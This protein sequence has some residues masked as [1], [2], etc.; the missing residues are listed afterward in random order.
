MNQQDVAKL[1]SVVAARY[2]TSKV[3]E[4]DEALT[5]QAWHMTLDDVPYPAAERAM[6]AWFKEHKWAPDASE[7]REEAFGLMARCRTPE[8]REA[9][10]PGWMARQGLVRQA[11]PRALEAS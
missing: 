3:W 4:Q 2:P 8:E 5:V 6:V 10:E 9:L 1:L 11:R 7:V